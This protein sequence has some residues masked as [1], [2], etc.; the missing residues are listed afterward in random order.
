MTR[1]LEEIIAALPPRERA[2]VEARAAEILAEE[3]SL[4]ELRKAMRKTQVSVAKKLNLSQDG[5]SKIERRTD[6]LISTLRG[7][8][9]AL[10][11]ELHLVAEFTDRPPVRLNEIG[12][13]AEREERARAAGTI[14]AR[15][16][17]A[18]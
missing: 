7:Y 5:V 11:G 16:R 12:S 8:V 10:G 4:R 17:T 15:R 13:I 1:K 3:M 2:A 18:A 9:K 6:L 14:R